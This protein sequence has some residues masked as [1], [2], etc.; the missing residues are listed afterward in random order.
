MKTV[1]RK[2]TVVGILLGVALLIGGSTLY[3]HFGPPGGAGFGNPGE[4]AVMITAY[5]T[6]KLDLDAAQQQELDAI[7]QKLLE[8]GK[9]HHA[10]HANARE[11]VL[12]ILRADTVDTQRV[13]LLQVQHQEA[14]SDLI[15]EA[16]NRLTEFVTMLRPEQRQR[17]AKLIEDHASGCPMR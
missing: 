12:S 15:A 9:T 13:Q 7:A 2:K 16:G 4:H 3:A 8:K 10:L 17:L 14:I 1:C 5:L 11:E 6:K